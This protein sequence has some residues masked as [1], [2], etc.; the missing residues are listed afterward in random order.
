VTDPRTLGESLCEPYDDEQRVW[1]AADPVAAIS[2]LTDLTIK[3][4]EPEDFGQSNC[5]VEG[6][7]FERQRRITVMRTGA[8]RTKF[9]L[10]HELGHDRARHTDSTA[11]VL[12]TIPAGSTRKFE[13]R[14]AD[15]FA[16]ELLVP[17]AV[18]DA[19]LEGRPPTAGD[20]AD[21]CDLVEGSMEA[22]CVRM[23]QRL[24]A[25][26]CVIL[27]EG[28]V[29]RFCAVTGDAFRIRRETDQGQDH[30]L[31]AASRHGSAV[32][33][34]VR[35]WHPS[36]VG[37]REYGGQAVSRDGF[38]FG[39]FTEATTPPWGGWRAPGDPNPVG[40][41]VLC[42]GC[43]R[44]VI[45]WVRCDICGGMRCPRED[46]LWCSCLGPTRVVVAERRCESCFLLKRV[47]LF[48]A[49]GAICSD[50]T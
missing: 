16:A 1:L 12:A 37:T 9:T 17:N 39:V 34:Q 24:G 50:C 49:A 38:V 43:A 42:G 28:S 23:V 40:V 20:V 3:V 11:E 18:A 5:S 46:C 10:L 45:A 4:C 7:Y 44:D 33:D 32:A 27:A 19:L 22:C 8:R 36:G 15:S 13:E 31:A 6:L 21:L 41:E 48:P 25:G 2:S 26:G 47:D 14:I 30:L 35:L 29:V